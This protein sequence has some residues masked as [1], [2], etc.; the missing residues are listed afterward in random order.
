MPRHIIKINDHYLLWS[1]VI[2]SPVGVC[3][4]SR[5]GSIEELYF[6]DYDPS[7]KELAFFN[8]LIER[9]KKHGTS[10]KTITSVEEFVRFNRAGQ[11]ERSLTLAEIYLVYCLGEPLNGW[12]P[13]QKSAS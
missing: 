4:E 12:S 2:D 7:E 10:H 11:D 5:F 9:V 6:Y 1:N 3:H 13:R 8:E